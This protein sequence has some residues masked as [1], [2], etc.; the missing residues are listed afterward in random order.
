MSAF[1]GKAAMTSSITY[2]LLLR[3]KYVQA[4]KSIETLR[5]TLPQHVNE[6]NLGDRTSELSRRDIRRAAASHSL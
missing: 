5:P 4:R 1:G 2:V 3:I 6:N